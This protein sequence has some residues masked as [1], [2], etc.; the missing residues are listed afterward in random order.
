MTKATSTK[1]AKATTIKKAKATRSKKAKATRNKKEFERWL[2]VRFI[3]RPAGSWV[4]WMDFGTQELTD[5]F[6]NQQVNRLQRRR[7]PMRKTTIAEF[8]DVA[9]LFPPASPNGY[10]CHVSRCGSTLLANA[11][12]AGGRSTVFSEAQPLYQLLNRDDFPGAGLEGEEITAVR[13][14]LLDAFLGLYAASF[15]NP[16]VVKG[17]TIDIMQIDKLRAIWPEMPIVISIRHPSEVIASNLEKSGDWINSILSPFGEKTLFGVAG[18]HFRQMSIEEYAVRGLEK[19]YDG[20][21]R[22]LDERTYVLD[23]SDLN[24]ETAWVLGRRF[25]LLEL[26]SDD[27]EILRVF[28]E[29]SKNPRKSFEPDQERKHRELTDSAHQLIERFAL[30]IYTRILHQSNVANL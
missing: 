23:Y 14:K 24:S 29:Y 19:L 15:A 5:P 26:A 20:A 6:F 21:Y 27:P 12:K 4:L 8:L 22:H 17:H 10:I 2:P 9:K 30:P 7:R 18:P 13:R 1:M 25:G 16:I 11:M 3:F 28:S